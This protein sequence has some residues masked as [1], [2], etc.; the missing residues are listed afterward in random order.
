MEKSDFIVRFSGKGGQGVLTSADGFASAATQLG[1]NSQT[2]ATFPS[3]IIGGPTWTQARVSTSRVLSRG[4]DLDVLVAFDRESFD[5]HRDEVQEGGVVIYNSGEFELE[6]GYRSLG[7]PFD[8]L[9]KSTGNPRAANMVVIGALAEL[10]S[11]P[12]PMI[13]EFVRKR[14]TRGRSNDEQVISSNIK[15]LALG[16][17]EAARSGFGLAP[18]A[19]PVKPA[20]PQILVNGNQAI[21]LGACAAGLQF[22]AGYPISPAN[23]ILSWMNGHLVGEDRLAYQVASEIEAINAVIGAGYAGAKAMTATSGPGLSLMSE[24]LGL[25]WMAEVPLVIA[26]IQRGGP[27]TGLPTKTEQ[28]DLFIAMSP[29]HGDAR[30]PIIAPG[31]V[32]ECFYGIVDAMNWAERYQGPV[33]LLSEHT[34]SERQENI[35]RPDLSKLEIERRIVYDGDGDYQR[36]GGTGLSPMPVPGHPGSYVA[37][38]SEHDTVG[39]TTHLASH[40][41][42][43]AQ[44]RFNKLKLLE[45]GSFEARNAKATVAIMPWGGSKGPVLEGYEKMTAEGDDLAWYYTM[46]LNPL[47]PGLIEALRQK[48]LVL[49]PEL[50]YQGQLSMILRSYGVR[51]E[52]ITQ[53]TGLPFRVKDVVKRIRERVRRE[54]PKSVVT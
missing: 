13:E 52:S 28:A 15:A 31:N 2:F 8:E 5:A 53:Y 41:V 6:K 14:F 43:M 48:D 23:T 33:L 45:N 18:L 50:N 27:S 42:E 25:A 47:P 12:Q 19:T 16:R 1:Y 37:N 21:C 32:E 54:R 44:R 46:Y 24:G 4:D 26:N 35:P 9:A 3:Q 30:L 7:I 29:A 20:Y 39:D 10:V 40:H 11:M 34:I 38:G 36:Y 49:V 22:Y 51:A 17:L